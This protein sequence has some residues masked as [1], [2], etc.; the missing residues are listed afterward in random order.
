[1]GKI[2]GDAVR[3]AGLW[4]ADQ[5]IAFPLVT[6]WGTNANGKTIRYYFNYSSRP[7]AFRYPHAPGKD[8]LS[9]RHV[10][11]GSQQEL[12]PWGVIIVLED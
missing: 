1:L 9:N 6:K 7:A 4:G 3:K 2:L 11:A 5:E 12:P 8:L 10:A